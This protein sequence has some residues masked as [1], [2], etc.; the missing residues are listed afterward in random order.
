MHDLLVEVRPNLPDG[1]VAV[2]DGLPDDPANRL[3]DEA[4]V[5]VVNIRRSRELAGAAS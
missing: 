1:V 2:I 5:C 3:G 4:S